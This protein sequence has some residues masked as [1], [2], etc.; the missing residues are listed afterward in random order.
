MMYFACEKCLAFIACTACAHALDKFPHAGQSNCLLAASWLVEP[1]RRHFRRTCSQFIPSN[2][3][4]TV[5][6]YGGYMKQFLLIISAACGI[7]NGEYGANCSPI[8]A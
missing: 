5:T 7:C 3:P 6:F 8:S 1:Q 2:S 4:S